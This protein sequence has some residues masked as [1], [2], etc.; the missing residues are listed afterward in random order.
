MGP[1][2]YG[3]S[4]TI[5]WLEPVGRCLGAILLKKKYLEHPQ[6]QELQYRLEALGIPKSLS[7]SLVCYDGVRSF[8]F[9]KVHIDFMQKRD[10]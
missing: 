6:I 2:R 1:F 8:G 7:T 10:E 3:E 9:W 5:D 4:W